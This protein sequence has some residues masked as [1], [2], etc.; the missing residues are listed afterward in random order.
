MDLSA[1]KLE[2]IEK[3]APFLRRALMAAA[4]KSKVYV[5]GGFTDQHQVERAVSI[6]DPVSEAWSEG[7][8]LPEGDPTAGF[9]PAVTVHAGSLY[10]SVSDGTLWRLKAGGNAWEQVA[11]TTPRLAHR[12]A[13]A[14]DRLL[15]LGGAAD[16][17]NFDLIEAVPVG[18][19]GS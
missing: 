13:S 17:S 3:P 2:W 16:G 7:P 6:Y 11:R 15:I 19:D 8:E 14:S 4:F 18:R 12:L 5:V 9:A 10:V 1:E